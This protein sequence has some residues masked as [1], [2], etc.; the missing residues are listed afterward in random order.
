MHRVK[1]HAQI[2]YLL[3]RINVMGDLVH[4]MEIASLEYA[5]MDIVQAP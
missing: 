1:R 2:A 3:L 5:L 4:L